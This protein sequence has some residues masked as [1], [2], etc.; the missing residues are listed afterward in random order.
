M[1]RLKI[2][3]FHAFLLALL[4]LGVLSW[5]G[6]RWFLMAMLVPDFVNS[7]MALA[8]QQMVIGKPESL[9]QAEQTL[10]AVLKQADME[11]DSKKPLKQ[12]VL[13]EYI[14]FLNKQHREKEAQPLSVELARLQAQ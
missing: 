9:L 6:L 10:K 3:P 5:L 1:K 14:D 12:R 4:I 2:R 8:H 7:G 13:K 11:A